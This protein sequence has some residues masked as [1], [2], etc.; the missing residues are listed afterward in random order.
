M[1]HRYSLSPILSSFRAGLVPPN[2][3]VVVRILLTS[4][5]C[6]SGLMTHV[7]DLANAL[8]KK[9]MEVAVAFRTTKPLEDGTYKEW[10]DRVNLPVFAYAS[11]R[12]L[13]GLCSAFEPQ[14]IHAHSP[15]CFH[16]CVKV[17][18]RTKIPLII[19]LHSTFPVQ[20]WYP[21]TL[22]IA[23]W[24]IAVG[25]A[26]AEVVPDYKQKTVIIPNG[27]DLERFK[28]N[29]QASG[30]V[31]KLCW[32]GRVHGNMSDGVVSLGQ[33]VQLAKADGAEL[34]AFFIGSASGFRKDHFIHVGWLDDPVSLLQ[35]TQ[36]A[37]GHGRSLREAMA[38]GNVGFLLGAGYGGQVTAH[39]LDELQHLDAFPEY[40]LPGAEPEHLAAE[41]LDLVSHPESISGLRQEA[42]QIALNH[43]NVE[44][45]ANAI[46]ELYAR[47]LSSSPP[48]PHPLRGVG[49]R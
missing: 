36:V 30:G 14:I 31:L 19:T 13:H 35:E 23:R 2:G 47:S 8:S 29:F 26:Q 48:L 16:S 41:I 18:A 34:E 9:G 45:M 49:R 32:F 44:T 27:I 22:M 38:C 10:L 46:L 21:L 12:D 6:K 4:I 33:A 40:G 7:L 24:I 43:F 37:F 5:L 11:S 1:S 39:L 3:G 28:P 17:T 20:K 42:R 25:P 15:D